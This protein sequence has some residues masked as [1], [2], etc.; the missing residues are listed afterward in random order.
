MKKL[1]LVFIAIVSISFTGNSQTYAYT[2]SWDQEG[3]V[4]RAQTAF[5][6]EVNFSVPSFSLEDLEVRGEDMKTI[7]LPGHFLPNDEGAPDLPGSGRYIALPQGARAV[8]RIV[9][10]RTERFRNVNI[11]PAPRIPKATERGPLDYNKD[12]RIYQADVFY[13][14]EPVKLSQPTLVR[15]VD[16]VILGITPFQYNPVTKELIVYRDLKV[17]VEFLGGNGQ[18]GEEKYRNR[19]WDPILSDLFL[20]SASL[21]EVDYSQRSLNANRSTGYEYLI[22]SPN[23]PVFLSWADSIRIFRNQ[24]GIYTGIVTTTEIGGNTTAAIES[25]V[26]NAYQTWDI[27]PAA[28]LLLGDYGTT[29]NTVISPVWDSY[30]VSDHIYAD[31]NADDEEEIIFA[32]MTARDNNELDIMISKALDYERNPPTSPDFYNHPI[33]ALGWQTERW[34]QICS[35]V[36]GGYFKYAQGKD[37]VRVNAVYDGNPDVDPWSTAPNTNTVLGVFG[38]NGLGYIPATPSELG[39]WTGGTATMVNNAINAGSFLLQHRDHGYEFGWGE[40]DYSNSSINGLTNTDLCFIFSINC[41]T[42]KYNHSSESFAE[43]F[44]R[45]TY[46]GQPA[47]ALGL[48]AASEVSYSFVNDTYVWG[49]FDNMFPD[50]MPQYGTNPPSRGMLPAF[51][52]AAGKYFLKYSSWP[53]NTDNKEVTY[54]LFHHHGDAFTCL[55]SEVPQNLTVAHNSVQLAGLG[56]FNVQADEGA[57][58]ALTVNGEIIGTATGT[59]APLDIA[60]VPQNPPD[61]ID[62]VVTKQNYYRYHAQVQTIPPNGPF[63]VTESFAIN[64]LLGNNNGQLDYGETINLDVTLKNLGTENAENVVV[65]ITSEDEFVTIADNSAEAGTIAPNQSATVTAAFTITAAGNVPNGHNIPFAMEATN[66]DTV[67][68]S[69]FSVKAYAP[70]LEYIDFAIADPTGNNDGHLDPGETA[71]LTVNIRNKGAADA[72]NVYGLLSTSDDFVQIEAD[73]SMFGNVGQNETGS[74]T[75]QVS[76]KVITPPGHLAEFH[77][78]CMADLGVTTGGGFELNV[79]RFPVLVLDLDNNHNS[80]S[81]IRDAINEWRIFAE[82]ATEIPDDLTQY[83]TIFLCLGTYN[84][85]HVLTQPEAIPFKNFLNGGGNMYME[86]ADTWYYDQQYN[87]TE[88]HPLFKITGLSDG[89]GDLGTVQGVT[90]TFVEGFTYY[91]NGDNSYIDRIAP[92]S[93]AY[94]IFNNVAPAYA[95]AVAHSSGVFKTIGSSFEFGGLLNNQLYDKKSLMLKYLN[96]FDMQPITEKPVTPVGETTVCGTETPCCYT[97]NPIENADYYIWELEPETAG[98]IE[99][100]D[101]TVTVHWTPGFKGTAN[102][103]VCGMNQGG[104]GPESD[105]L[106]VNVSEIP[107]ATL[108]FSTTTICSGESAN[109]DIDLTG[110]GPWHLVINF[111]GYQLTFDPDKPQVYGIPV[112]PVTDLEIT[113]VSLSDAS[114]CENTDFET[115]SI[116]VLPMPSVPAKAS[117]PEYVDV[118]TTV[119]SVYQTTGAADADSYQWSLEPPTAGSLLPGA[120]GLDCTVQ[121]QT[122]FTGAAALKVKALN[123]CG[124]SVFS[125]A[126]AVNVANT[127]GVDENKS[128]LGIAIYPNP[129]AG[130][131]R[132]DLQSPKPTRTVISLINASGENVIVP[133]E[134]EVGQTRSIPVLTGNIAEGMYLIRFETAQGASSRKLVIRK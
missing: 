71:E 107:T 101:T 58:I 86:G 29:G 122:G 25:Y 17:E 66:G 92:I 131:F 80:G 53:Y 78:D 47:G 63:V 16:A 129:N 124:E 115:Y 89:S 21:P 119:Q 111:G 127:F 39:G 110:T 98:T 83:R 133:M 97:I 112:N 90:G 38:P 3:F 20:N 49:V 23:D 85:N 87:P 36:V 130:D 69:T 91:F 27:P 19:W 134:V 22:I 54:N 114:G 120:T 34:F 24:Q 123:Q 100:W 93:P 104:L 82:Y 68:N 50:F 67:W 13:P 41:L 12:M 117:G 72:Y 33:T 37:P 94:T 9:S 121:W 14:A 32:R 81:L 128:G 99:G 65:T 55:F 45:Y 57:F 73:S 77:I 51:G 116:D 102:L 76:A 31:V 56:S 106:A 108:T 2:D 125:E 40:P 70:I 103:L 46:N 8:V 118:F 1:L 18:F 35:E 48:L 64:D 126:L 84:S 4:L 26:N 15:G 109:L 132:I 60:I 95:T 113:I 7:A 79:G 61:M 52:N 6:I 75:F 96:F 59:G 44:H 62:V 11:A 88:L 43:K 5:G 28:I 74:M 105:A 42:G 30:C 10:S